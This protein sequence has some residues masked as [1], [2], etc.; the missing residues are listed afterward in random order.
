M[1]YKS[2][3]RGIRTYHEDFRLCTISLWLRNIS[4]DYF[5]SDEFD[6]LVDLLDGVISI[7]AVTYVLSKLS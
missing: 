3:E 6:S 1:G 2:D 5:R 7:D 4:R